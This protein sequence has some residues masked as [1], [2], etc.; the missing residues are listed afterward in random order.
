VTASAAAI[1][2][3]CPFEDR[4]FLK[5]AYRFQVEHIGKQ[6]ELYFGKRLMLL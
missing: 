6:G 3:N 5:V 2:G 4:F 1:L